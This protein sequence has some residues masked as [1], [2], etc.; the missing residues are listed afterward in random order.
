MFKTP[1]C[2]QDSTIET[3]HTKCFIPLIRWPSSKSC[4][5]KHCYSLHKVFG[6][7]SKK[8]TILALI[9]YFIST[10]F[11]KSFEKRETIHLKES[12]YVFISSMH[13]CSQSRLV[14]ANKH[15]FVNEVIFTEPY[16]SIG[17]QMSKALLHHIVFFM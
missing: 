15:I 8:G 11:L 3:I 12:M 13:C 7:I 4:C 5:W 1:V 2:F 6:Q 9:H 10:L 16:C 14:N 17:I